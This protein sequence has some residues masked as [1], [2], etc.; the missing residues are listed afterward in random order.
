MQTSTDVI[1]HDDGRVELRDHTSIEHSRLYSE[2]LAPVPVAKRN[3]STYNYA[4]LWIS[5]AHCIPT[6]MLS[7]GLIAAGMNWWQALIT[8]LIGNTIVLIPILLNSHPGTKY[9]IP[10]PVFARASYGT[11]GSNLPAIMRALVACGWFGIQAWIGGQ[12]LH[13]FMKSIIPAW[14][15]LLGGPIA[16]YPPTEWLSFLVF[17][18]MNIYI[19]YRGMNLLRMV[20][21]WAAPFVLVMTALLLAWA[22]WRAGGLGYLVTHPG[23]LTTWAKFKPVFIPKLTAMIGFWATLSLNMPDFTRFGRSQREQAI[24]QTVA[25][26]TTMTVFAAM[27]VI[28]T[29]AAAVIYANESINQLWDP[30]L[31]VGHFTQPVIVAISM[32]TVVV[33]TLSVNI[34]AN[35][36]SP[37]NDFA[38]AMPKYISFRTGGLITGILGILIRPWRLMADPARYFGWL[39][40]YSGGLGSIAGVLIADYWIVRDKNFVLADLYKEEGTYAYWKGWNWR[41]VIATAFGCFLAWGGKFEVLAFMQP[42]VDYGWFVGF[43]ASFIIYVVLMKMARPAAMTEPEAA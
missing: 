4:A 43:G 34:A 10:F 30:V 7:S 25:L 31:L 23:N 6:Y 14:P 22:V 15:T 13:T 27:G 18:G 1:R 37:A 16:G 5:M 28:I 42:L 35:V 39:S 38:N 40:D 17:W 41:A 32:F 21:N 9:G 8:I 12:A 26:P 2:D 24:G 3:W 29:S 33:A 11:Y 19:I 20:E 36:V